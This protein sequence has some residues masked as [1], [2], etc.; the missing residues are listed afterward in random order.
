M[1]GSVCAAWSVQKIRH[2]FDQAIGFQS[3]H[4]HRTYAEVLSTK[5]DIPL[6]YTQCS[7]KYGRSI[8]GLG[9]TYCSGA[10]FTKGLRLRLSQGLISESFV[11]AKSWT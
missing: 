9:N 5:G 6:S 11:F 3:N 2:V 7:P 10:G 1:E 8:S 4:D